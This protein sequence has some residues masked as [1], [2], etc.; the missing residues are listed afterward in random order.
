MLAATN[1]LD[2]SALILGIIYLLLF[3]CECQQ[4]ISACFS[5]NKLITYRNGIMMVLCTSALCRWLVW[6]KVLLVDAFYVDDTLMMILYFLPVW[7]NFCAIS[8]LCVFYAY[9]LFEGFFGNYPWYITFVLNICF[10]VFN[11]TIAY[12]LNVSTGPN[13]TLIYDIYISYAIFLDTFTALLLA[14]FGY[15]F[16][17]IQHRRQRHWLFQSLPKSPETFTAMNLLIVA[18]FLLRSVLVGLL[19]SGLFTPKEDSSVR[20]NVDPT[21]NDIDQEASTYHT[22]YTILFFYLSTEVVPNLAMLYLLYVPPTANSTGK[23]IDRLRL[24]ETCAKR[25]DSI[26]DEDE[27]D[28]SGLE[29][30]DSMDFTENTDD[31]LAKLLFKKSKKRK[32]HKQKKKI[33]IQ[34]IMT[35]FSPSKTTQPSSQQRNSRK[36]SKFFYYFEEGQLKKQSLSPNNVNDA[37]QSSG[38]YQPIAQRASHLTGTF[39]H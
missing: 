30:R 33:T 22:S 13:T 31:K 34:S 12:L 9:V 26:D 19:S 15:H 39:I 29:D 25:D 6:G 3:V 36:K 4:I 10:A 35:M 17:R 24:C 2:V 21:V 1:H 32:L 8:M 37:R 18:C 16:Y 28:E 27:E 11:I 5:K 14:Y 23:C 7:L 38:S 20:F